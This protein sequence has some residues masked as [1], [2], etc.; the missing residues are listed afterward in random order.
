[1]FDVLSSKVKV[2]GYER[3]GVVAMQNAKRREVAAKPNAKR[4]PAK[5]ESESRIVKLY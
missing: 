3:S 4:S 2:K 5:R 1:M